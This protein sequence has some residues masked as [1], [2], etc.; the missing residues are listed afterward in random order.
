MTKEA[1]LTNRNNLTSTG[2]EPRTSRITCLPD[3]NIFTK[4]DETILEADMPGVNESS[5]E[6]MLDNDILTVKGTQIIDV[7]DGFIPVRGEFA[8]TEFTRRFEVSHD[9]DRNRITANVRNGVLRVVLPKG[10]HAK[11]KKIAISTN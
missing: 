9:I 11:P 10:E 6:V 8:P 3:V 7:P 2:Q 4:S 1:E 5:V